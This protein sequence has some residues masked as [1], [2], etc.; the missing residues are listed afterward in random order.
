VLLIAFG[1]LPVLAGVLVI[2]KAV[3]NAQQ[4]TG[5]DAFFQVAWHNLGATE[6]FPDHIGEHA[7]L[8]DAASGLD[9]WYRAGVAEE[10]TCADGF[11]GQ[12][13]EEASRYQCTTLLR[14]TYI[15]LTDSVAA[16]VAVAVMDKTGADALYEYDYDKGRDVGAV[17]HAYPV[18][19]TP[20]AGWSDDHAV[21]SD[22]RPVSS[23]ETDQAYLMAAT[24]GPLD[25]RT[26]AQLP[27]VWRYSERKEVEPY[28]G[29]A[30][31]VA[32]HLQSKFDTAREAGS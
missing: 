21:A 25:G 29:I 2:G 15:D 22:V 10:T 1:I 20:A 24:V 7:E 8:V 14:A 5:N 12:F 16:T 32:S 18:E 17:L 28:F 26:V 3:S 9:T 30:T 6:I 11:R 19:G 4:T 31:Q 13:L 27:G 23:D